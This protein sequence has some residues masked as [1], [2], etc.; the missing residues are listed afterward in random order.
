MPRAT[1][2][3]YAFDA[4]CAA[5]GAP[6]LWL[7]DSEAD[8]IDGGF[9]DED[10]EFVPEYVRPGRSSLAYAGKQSAEE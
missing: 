1:S 5:D 3:R 4:F 9:S 2:K 7:V 10:I 8:D 6:G